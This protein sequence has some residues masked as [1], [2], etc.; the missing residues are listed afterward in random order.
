[1]Q[2]YSYPL[3]NLLLLSLVAA[4]TAGHTKKLVTNALLMIGYS[5]G[6]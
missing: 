3:A 4:N 2:I 1:V 5:V 6:K